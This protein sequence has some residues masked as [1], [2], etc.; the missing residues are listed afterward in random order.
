MDKV[1]YQFIFPN[2]FFGKIGNEN[3]F[4]Q[5]DGYSIDDA[6]LNIIKHEIKEN[7]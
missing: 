5:F 4:G 1:C 3:G 2:H 7:I 6:N